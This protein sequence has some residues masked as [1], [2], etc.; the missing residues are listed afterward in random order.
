[1]LGGVG[2]KI[3]LEIAGET[4]NPMDKNRHNKLLTNPK[5]TNL[6]V[7]TSIALLLAG[8]LY[9]FMVPIYG[10]WN[11]IIA[12]CYAA[13]VTVLIIVFGMPPTGRSI[14][15]GS[16]SI[17]SFIAWC[18]IVPVIAGSLSALIIT[19]IAHMQIIYEYFK[20]YMQ[21]T[22]ILLLFSISNCFKFALKCFVLHI[23]IG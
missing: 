12:T 8:E 11:K 20:K 10:L 4:I 23:Y 21:N 18:I 22:Y 1:M 13:A 7:L 5:F 3:W 9:I 16:V 15:F 17:I 2:N 6:V 19:K 14:G